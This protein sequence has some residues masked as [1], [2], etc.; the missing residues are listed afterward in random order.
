MSIIDEVSCLDWR[1]VP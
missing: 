1:P